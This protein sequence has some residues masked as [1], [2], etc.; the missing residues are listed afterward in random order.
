MKTLNRLKC[1]P[2]KELAIEYKICYIIDTNKEATAHK[3]LTD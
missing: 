1:A 3:G 2:E